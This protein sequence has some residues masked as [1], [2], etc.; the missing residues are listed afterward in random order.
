MA[1]EPGRRQVFFA[2]ACVALFGGSVSAA[3]APHP[4]RLEIE[5][6]GA[7]TTILVVGEA[8]EPVQAT[9]EL[10]VD[11]ASTVR[12]SGNATLR[13]GTRTVVARVRIGGDAGWR[14]EL[15]VTPRGGAPYVMNAAA[16]D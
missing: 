4:V 14:A 10:A 5:Q 11:G 13:P 1:S 7:D 15:R 2:A 8:A 3:A 6:A 9:Y 12:Q 16:A